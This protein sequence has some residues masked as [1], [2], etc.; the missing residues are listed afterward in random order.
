VV[1]KLSPP[2]PPQTDW[3]ETVLHSF[4]SSP[5]CADGALPFAGL[6][7]DSEGNLYGTTAYGG[8]SGLGVL[9][10]LPPRGPLRVLHSFDG[11]DGSQ[12]GAGVI[13]DTSGNLYGTT[14]NGGAA[15]LGGAAGG[16][17]VFK[18][19]K[20]GTFVVL[21]SFC[22]RSQCDD[23]SHPQAG[24]YLDAQHNL[25]GTTANGGE[26]DEGVVFELGTDGGSFR[27][28]YSFCR[29]PRC[30][31]GDVPLGGLIAD[32]S[33][34]LYGTTS[35]GGEF[36]G[37]VVFELSPPI[38]PALEWTETVLHD[39]CSSISS[40]AICSDG[41]NPVAGL[42]ADRFG[43]LFGTT[44]D[45]GAFDYRGVAFK[46]SPPPPG[47]TN[48]FL[49]VLHSFCRMPGCPDGK[50]PRAGLVADG[51]G[52]LYG[53]AL[54][55]VPVRGVVFELTDA[56][57]FPP[58]IPFSN[59][60]ARLEIDLDANPTDDAFLLLSEVAL[61][62]G[63]GG[64]NPPAKPVFLTIGPFTTKIPHGSFIPGGPGVFTFAGVINGV[65]LQVGI[66]QQTPGN[67]SFAVAA[68]G[69]DLTGIKNP[70]PVAL[71]IGV[72]TGTAAVDAQIAP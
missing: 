38:P 24:L 60:T 63:S 1:F 3:T 21:H 40:I 69:A 65:D 41:A 7:A 27:V 57:F 4:C 51:E 28:L 37:G 14:A 55:A 26:F 20:D 68:Q 56:G 43:N 54:S 13:A 45:G 19:T 29:T 48:W 70:V 8:A 16:G 36:G 31:D 25:Y 33:G 58:P 23:G 12:P 5:F 39:F 59:F 52:N 50:K 15:A 35:N 67:F 2:V 18:R 47:G 49:E 64:I 71:T 22:S 42:I 34:N 11:S 6:F 46:L 30:P 62:A 32:G 61:G 9:F 53:M 44:L 66:E 17:T 72:D 10:K